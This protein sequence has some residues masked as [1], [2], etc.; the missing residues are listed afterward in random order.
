LLAGW[1]VVK[2]S[3]DAA[4]SGIPKVKVAF[5]RDFG[6]VSWRAFFAKFVAGEGSPAELLPVKIIDAATPVGIAL[7]QMIN[8]PVPLLILTASSRGNPIAIVTL[9]DVFRHQMKAL[10]E[11]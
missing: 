1:I 6:D 9:H 8:E 2:V 11:G 3:R 10:E 4:G 5:W 7:R